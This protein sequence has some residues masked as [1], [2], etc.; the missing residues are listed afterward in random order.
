MITRPKIWLVCEKCGEFFSEEMAKE[1]DICSD[2]KEGKLKI[3]CAECG[4][5]LNECKCVKNKETLL[6]QFKKLNYNQ[7]EYLLDRLGTRFANPIKDI[8]PEEIYATFELDYS[9]EILQKE[10]DNLLNKEEIK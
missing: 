3:I 1:D 9:A 5:W 10:L 4:N 6:E 2:C 7:I 8:P